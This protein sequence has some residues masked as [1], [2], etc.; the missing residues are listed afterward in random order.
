LIKS[1]T[2]IGQV[3][4]LELVESNLKEKNE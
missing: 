4:L 2:D 3:C 1:H